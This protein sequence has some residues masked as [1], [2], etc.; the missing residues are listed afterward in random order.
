MKK[1]F[2]KEY[3]DELIKRGESLGR[4]EYHPL[5][6]GFSYS[7]ISG[8][9]YDQWISE[10]KILNERYLKSHPLYESIKNA[11]KKSKAYS[12]LMGYLRALAE[13]DVFWEEVSE[14][15][16]KTNMQSGRT[17]EQL[18]SEDIERCERFL[19]DPSDLNTGKNLYTEITSRYDSIIKGFGKGLYQYFDEANFYDPDLSKDSL[20]HNLKVL[21]GRM[22]SYQATNYPPKTYPIVNNHQ[23]NA[24]W[25]TL[26]K[27]GVPP[28][29]ENSG[30]MLFSFVVV[31]LPYVVGSLLPN[32][33]V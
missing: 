33:P 25:D 12:E 4:S 20:I 16:K 18:L 15:E 1:K 11:F 10:I 30:F 31:F 2:S 13:D 21:H 22:L 7:H 6:D 23:K 24:L 26:H 8:P 17:I 3:I 14:K 27:E 28:I 19:N 29:F 32:L 9:Q 5:A